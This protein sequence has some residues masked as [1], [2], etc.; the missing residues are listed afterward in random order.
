MELPAQDQLAR[1]ASENPFKHSALSTLQ[2]AI[3]RS[4]QIPDCSQRTNALASGFSVPA[5]SSAQ[6]TSQSTTAFN[7]HHST[8]LVHGTQFRLPEAQ[9]VSPISYS[10]PIQS[11]G[12]GKVCIDKRSAD[13]KVQLPK[14]THSGHTSPYTVNDPYGQFLHSHQ[15]TQQGSFENQQLQRRDFRLQYDRHDVDVEALH[16][17]LTRDFGNFNVSERWTSTADDTFASYGSNGFSLNCAQSY[18]QSPPLSAVPHSPNYTYSSANSNTVNHQ[19]MDLSNSFVPPILS[20]QARVD[21]PRSLVTS[22]KDNRGLSAGPSPSGDVSPGTNY[23]IHSSSRHNQ[24]QQAGSNSRVMFDPRS[25][26]FTSYQHS[27]ANAQMRL[28]ANSVNWPALEQRVDY[29]QFAPQ[30]Q[31]VVQQRI[32]S[33]L[34]VQEFVPEEVNVDWTSLFL[35]EFKSNLKKNSRGRRAELSVSVS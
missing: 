35:E 19:W 17:S 28:P 1:R 20:R 6:T 18:P 13:G 25:P 22:I 4:T 26:S 31:Q 30:V 7:T 8:D 9:S 34:N 24:P 15:I 3:P 27:V 33:H 11:S 23:S 10:F 21:H 2:T 29:S 12:G 5:R 14:Q 32:A 16:A